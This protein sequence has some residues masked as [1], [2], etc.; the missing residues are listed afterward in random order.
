MGTNIKFIPQL[1]SNEC[2]FPYHEFKASDFHL[3]TMG[4]DLTLMYPLTTVVPETITL[5]FKG[6]L[7]G[8]KKDL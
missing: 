8:N 4:Q 3:L 7:W 1:R 2:P 5:E 6:C